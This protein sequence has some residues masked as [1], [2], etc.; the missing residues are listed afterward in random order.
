[1]KITLKKVCAAV[2]LLAIAGSAFAGGSFASMPKYVK[3]SLGYGYSEAEV[4]YEWK[5]EAL[6]ASGSAT[7]SA[8]FN[9]FMVQAAFGVM[10]WTKSDNIVLKGLAV[11][12]ACDFGF[13]GNDSFVDSTLIRPGVMAV[14]SYTFKNG[15]KGVPFGGV[16]FSVPIQILSGD[17]DISDTDIGFTVDIKAG[18]GYDFTEKLRGSAEYK[19]SFGTGLGWM[20]GV[21]CQYFLGK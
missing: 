10:P 21:G 20:L 1:M 13:G 7:Y 12:G 19:L 4:E 16:G 17:Y 15:F 14:Y 3:G 2:M 9:Y 11:E 8:V 6:D 5:W 18:F